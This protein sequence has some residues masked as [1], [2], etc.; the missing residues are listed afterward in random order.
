M[1]MASSLPRWERLRSYVRGAAYAIVFVT[2]HPSAMS[3]A[4]R[5]ISA[6]RILQTRTAAPHLHREC[7]F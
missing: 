7:S 6:H 3:S 4:L 2:P 1:L 5:D